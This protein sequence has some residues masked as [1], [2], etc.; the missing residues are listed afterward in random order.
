VCFALSEPWK[1]KSD[2]CD[3]AIESLS[4]GYNRADLK[5]LKVTN[6]LAYQ[7]LRKSFLTLIA[8]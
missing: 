3:W 8:T 6:A 4:Y 2:V 1:F 5:G 7:W